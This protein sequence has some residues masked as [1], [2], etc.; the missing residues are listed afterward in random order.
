MKK[1]LILSLIATLSPIAGN[2]A[3]ILASGTCGSSA[4]AC[5]FTLDDQGNLR[6][7]GNGKIATD[8]FARWRYPNLSDDSIKEVVIN[9]GIT[10]VSSNAINGWG[11]LNSVTIPKSV[12]KIDRMAFHYLGSLKNLTI[13]GENTE[14]LSQSFESTGLGNIH[15]YGKSISC[16]PGS[17]TE[18]M[19]KTAI[20]Y[21]YQI[22][23]RGPSFITMSAISKKPRWTTSEIN[24]VMGDS[25]TGEMIFTFK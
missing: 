3:E 10:G 11:K 21:D 7:S 9:N 18:E 23:T 4:E 12:T 8:A 2:A 19:L 15:L 24:E 20:S 25:K 17:K 14:I 13:K 16:P 6:I 1:F 22:R 5:S